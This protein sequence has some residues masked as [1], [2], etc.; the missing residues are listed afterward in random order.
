MM[1]AAVLAGTWGGTVQ[2]AWPSVEGPEPPFGDSSLRGAALGSP[3]VFWGSTSLAFH[4]GTKGNAR[5][6]HQSSGYQHPYRAQGG[7][8]GEL[9][10]GVF[11]VRMPGVSSATTGLCR[12]LLDPL[13][14]PHWVFFPRSP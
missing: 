7:D 14:C 10:S 8:A 3:L 4:T 13:L 12:P 6:A 2:G 5:L 11:P 9:G 1:M